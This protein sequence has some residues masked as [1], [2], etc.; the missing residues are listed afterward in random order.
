MN[1]TRRKARAPIVGI[2]TAAL[3]A[4]GGLLATP[5]HAAP[6]ALTL[7]TG[8][9]SP[10]VAN[11]GYGAVA[12][13]NTAYAMKITG[14]DGAVS[15]DVVSGPTGG[16]IAYE[17][18]ASNGAATTGF[19]QLSTHAAEVQ[20]VTISG[21]P[22]GGTFTLTYSGQT[23]A[24]IAYNANAAAVQAALEALSNLAPGDV[25]VTGGPGPGSAFT[26]TFGATLAGQNVAELTASGALLT[27]GTTPAV[28]VATTTQ[29]ATANDLDSLGTVAS[30][31][32]LY[33][34][35]N[36]PGT[37]TVRAF[38]DTN[39]NGQL[40]ADDERAA[41][42]ITMTVLDAGG[43]GTTTATTDD[44]EP[45][46][47]STSPITKG[48]AVTATITYSDSL[49]TSDARG[50]NVANGL[51]DRLAALTAV[52]VED[53]TTGVGDDTNAAAS[54]SA[55]T[56]ATTYT[57][58]TPATVGTIT[59]RA[60]LKPTLGATDNT[61][62]GSKIIQVTDNGTT[63]LSLEATEVDGAVIHPT[64]STVTVKSGTSAVT[65]VATAV[66]ENGAGTAD[67]EPVSGA[68]VYFTLG[69][70]DVASLTTNGT[71]VNAGSYVYS[72]TTNSD[73]EASLIVTS[74]VTL[75]DDQYT[76]A[77]TT[78]AVNSVPPTIT[79]T[80][81]DREAAE[82]EITNTAA[83]LTPSV[84]SAVTIEGRLLDQFEVAFQPASS[85]AQ[86]VTVG[87][88]VGATSY[89]SADVTQYGVLA[90]GSFTS[91]YT[92]TTTPSSGQTDSFRLTYGAVTEDGAIHWAST[93]AASSV[94]LTTPRNDA[95]GINLSDY[96]TLVTTQSN[97]T[98][99]GTA[100]ADDDDFGDAN[101]QIT[102][103][104]YDA[105]NNP[106]AY[107][108]VTITGSTGVYF[109][110]ASTGEDLATSITTVTNASGAIS[111]V[112]A[113]FTK[114]GTATVTAT[115][116]SATDMATLTTDDAADAYSVTV[117]DV[118]GTPGET[119][120]VTGSVKDMFGNAVPS[121]EVDLSIGTSTLGVLGD[122]S[123]E[124]NSAGVFSTTFQSGSNQSGTATLTATLD[125]Q[126]SNKEADDTIWGDDLAGL[127]AFADGDYQDASTI[128]ITAVDLTLSATG[129][130]EGYGDAELSGSYKP[131]MT[132]DIYAKPHGADSFSLVDSVK[133]DDDGNYGTSIAITKITS[134]L[135]RSGDVSSEVKTTIVESKVTLKVKAKGSGIVQLDMNGD[136]NAERKTTFYLV[137][138]GGKL[139]P[140]KTVWTN[141]KGQARVFVVFKKKGAKTFRA[142]YAAPHTKVGFGQATVTVT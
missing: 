54:Y 75:D 87:I 47:A 33:L 130:I 21:T 67:D 138:K 50:S 117:D 22:T 70:T 137:G 77:A 122:S 136:P 40:D 80:Y 90:G 93:T 133:T 63:A 141:E 69:G 86:Q 104:V 38:Q 46:I 125:G 53:G 59:M 65:Y 121:S 15:L 113:F 95:S 13:A 103:T 43:T 129:S 114:S 102:G 66:D 45:M 110:E 23:T 84:G 118:T 4:A 58:G 8:A 7:S 36:V 115:S 119:M 29:G 101:G 85:A 108:S 28:A 96:N 131:N 94:T 2:G 39:G 73:G 32:Y 107:K 89:S 116:G 124:T 128:T 10:V 41:P 106:L 99:G 98:T 11:L 27:G 112:Y 25:A 1:I 140:L 55:T 134:W 123:P 74:A 111:G 37:Y 60:D 35:G 31:D 48:V 71:L 68:D 83:E 9:T 51:K 126:S 56:G 61:S 72:A 57:P 34:T 64:S 78:N 19:T 82:I 139:V 132:V 135:A 142:Y 26:L 24:G 16:S 127:P 76:V 105:S 120:I 20:T 92:P 30:S 81:A 97:A 18:V 14:S 91:T 6:T 42:L 49:S 62:Y 109:A 17:K 5:A 79:T 52:D 44:V 12:A 88:D 3:V 100:G